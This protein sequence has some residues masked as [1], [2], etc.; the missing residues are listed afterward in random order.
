MKESLSFPTHPTLA[1]MTLRLRYRAA[2]ALS[3]LAP[4]AASLGAV[5]FE[6]EIWPILQKKCVDCHRAPYEENGRKKEPKGG[7]RLDAAWA[8]IKG[9]EHGPILKPKDSAASSL[10]KV[11]TLP[12]D[13]DDFMPPK[14]DPLTEDEV[15]LLKAWIDEGANFDG[16][17]GEKAGQPAE[18]AKVPQ[19]MTKRQHE[20]FYKALEADAKPVPE[21][22]LKKAKEA[23][24]QIS[25]ISTTSPLLRVDF[26]TGVSACTDEKV[27]AL[28][29]LAGNIAHLDLGR[30]AITDAALATV[31]KMPRLAKLDLRQ[32]KITDAALEHLTGLKSLTTVNLFGT[33]VTDAGIKTLT[34]NK[35]IQNI[36]AFQTKVTPAAASA[37]SGVNIIIK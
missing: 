6:K 23:G 28:L 22:V 18:L 7:L 15:K 19:V 33:E 25:P 2:L 31:A 29:P 8:I 20:E 13:D 34:G 36:Y 37:A 21:D 3:L 16:W 10:Y 5:N 14:G 12:K 1:P 11:V 27:A 32:T 30:T 17:E 9:S 4:C 24:A 35:S 26:L